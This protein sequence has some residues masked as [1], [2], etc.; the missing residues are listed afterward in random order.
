[1]FT[2]PPSNTNAPTTHGDA[3][4]RPTAITGNGAAAGGTHS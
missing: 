4:T 1:M 2:K 3:T